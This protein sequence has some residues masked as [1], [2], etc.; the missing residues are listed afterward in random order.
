MKGCVSKAAV[1]ITSSNQAKALGWTPVE[2]GLFC[3]N[4]IGTY[5][6]P[7]KNIYTEPAAEVRR[8]FSGRLCFDTSAKNGKVAGG[9]TGKKIKLSPAGDKFNLS[10]V[11]D[12]HQLE[13]KIQ[14]LHL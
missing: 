5:R 4:G 13:P 10:P 3:G 9:H 11:N 1:P 6:N 14:P 8:D 2:S 7:D 12:Y